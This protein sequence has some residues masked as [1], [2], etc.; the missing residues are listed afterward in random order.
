M[1]QNYLLKKGPQICNTVFRVCAF[2]FSFVL[3]LNLT[4]QQTY[5]FTNASATGSAG[6]TQGQVNTAY[7]STNLNGSVVVN[8][9]GIQ[10]FTIPV[11]GPYRIQARGGQGYGTFGGRGAIMIGDFTLT[12]GTVLK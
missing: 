7:G 5:S 9:Q 6:P 3:S 8:P 10:N 12:A 4:A 1:K 11:S 2:L